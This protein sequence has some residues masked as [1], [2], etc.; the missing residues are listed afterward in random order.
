[1]V[2]AV[3]VVVVVVGMSSVLVCDVLGSFWA[4]PAHAILPPPLTPT[5][6]IHAH[7]HT[8]PNTSVLVTPLKAR[9]THVVRQHG[10]PLPSPTPS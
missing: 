9:C 8:H 10:D 7:V 3:A 5:P 6:N 2:V 1:V 4:A